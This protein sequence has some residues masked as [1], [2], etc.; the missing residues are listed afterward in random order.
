MGSEDDWTRHGVT[1]IN[2]YILFKKIQFCVNFQ[3]SSHRSLEEVNKL[4]DAASLV[5]R[6]G[7][8]QVLH[9]SVNPNS[10]EY[11]L[12]ELPQSILETLVVGNR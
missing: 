7:P 2:L 12:L 4:A 10:D 5:N 9:F 8:V 11:K 1:S 6:T 3:Y